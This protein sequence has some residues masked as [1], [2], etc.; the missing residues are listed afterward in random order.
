MT[1]L[2]KYEDWCNK[3]LDGIERW[4]NYST[5]CRTKSGRRNQYSKNIWYRNVYTNFR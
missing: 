1:L 3:E 4:I 2:E 5:F